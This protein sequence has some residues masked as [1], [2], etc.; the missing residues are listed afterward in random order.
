MKERRRRADR[1]VA[2]TSAFVVVAAGAFAVALPDALVFL[3]LPNDVV[4]YIAAAKSWIHGS[5]FVNPVLYSYYLG[6]ATPPVPAIAIQAPVVS[7][8]FA[9]VL[10]LGTG[11]VGLGVAHAPT[12][13]IDVDLTMILIVVLVEL[14]RNGVAIQTKGRGIEVMAR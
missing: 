10:G 6:D 3:R 9:G 11:L 14:I 13:C 7:V 12:I 5:G 8:L 2:M 1:R 4:V